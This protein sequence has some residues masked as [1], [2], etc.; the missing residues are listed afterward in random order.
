MNVTN[1]SIPQEVYATDPIPV[2]LSDPIIVPDDSNKEIVSGYIRISNTSPGPKIIYTVPGT[3]RFILTDMIVAVGGDNLYF[4]LKDDTVTKLRME[5]I[6]YSL[7]KKV[8][9]FTSLLPLAA[10][11]FFTN[12]KTI[13]LCSM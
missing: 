7:S 2:T 8:D 9:R 11:S 6:L 12:S 4:Y 3:H 10:N 1:D 5:S 13:L